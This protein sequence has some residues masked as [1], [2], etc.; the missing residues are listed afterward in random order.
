MASLST[1]AE[2]MNSLTSLM[3]M[4][5][6]VSAVEPSALVARTVMLRLLPSVSRS[7]AVAPVV[8][9]PVVG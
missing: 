6:I 8:T 5:K 1:G 9:T 7:I 2:T 4:L 3:A